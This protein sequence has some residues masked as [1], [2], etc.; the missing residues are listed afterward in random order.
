MWRI[1]LIGGLGGVLPSLLD[2]VQAWNSGEVARWLESAPN[3][4]I[5]ILVAAV[6]IAFY[7]LCGALIAAIYESQSAQKALLIGLGAPAFILSA[8]NNTND[9]PNQ[10]QITGSLGAGLV[11]VAFA[12][13]VAASPD[14]QLKLDNLVTG[15]GCGDCSVTF[16]GEGRQPIAREPLS[17]AAQSGPLT[18]PEETQVI[19]FNGSDAN[20]AE[21]DLRQLEASGMS[22]EG[23]VTL[24]VGIRRSYWNDLARS[25]GAKD[26]QPYSFSIE[27]DQR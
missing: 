21:L 14:V 25:F 22:S 26:V 19:L 7:F 3:P 6:P 27:S 20:A 15:Q 9:Q 13:S 5:A 18:V 11:G 16:L 12:R 4:L 10:I 24:D 23:P 8:V 1:V 2:K 17:Q